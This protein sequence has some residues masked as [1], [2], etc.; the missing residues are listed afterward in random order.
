MAKSPAGRYL[1]FRS[2]GRKIMISFR[3]FTAFTLALMLALFTS[4]TAWAA[5]GAG[6]RAPD[7]IGKTVQGETLKLANFAGKV[8]VLSFW[9]AACERCLR[10]LS[11]LE[12]LQKVGKGRV[13]VIAINTDTKSQFR[14][15][16]GQLSTLTATLTHDTDEKAHMAYGVRGMP[17][18]V[19]IGRDGK[20]VEVHRGYSEAA[21]AEI[22]ND[23]NFAVSAPAPVPVQN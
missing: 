23:I 9:A 2:H 15:A 7:R 12:S 17:H 20:I 4:A 8:V 22:I 6:D 5:P 19:I 14:D 3:N 1:I 13:Q 18:L 11:I 16:A 10:E 21:L